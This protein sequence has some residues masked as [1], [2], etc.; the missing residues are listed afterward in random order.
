MTKNQIKANN[1]IRDVLQKYGV[2]INQNDRC[3]CFIH[4]GKDYNM[5]I[6]DEYVKCFVCGQKA[7]IFSVVRHFEGCDFVEAMRILGGEQDLSY[8]QFR[9]ATRREQAIREKLALEKR[10]KDINFTEMQEYYKLT[11]ILRVKGQELG[12]YAF[13]DE[14]FIQAIQD[15]ARNGVTKALWMN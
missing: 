4:G 9:A 14:E 13:Q 8:E 3:K 5:S 1:S 2:H 7:D 11:D 15:L 10:L 12:E 6:K